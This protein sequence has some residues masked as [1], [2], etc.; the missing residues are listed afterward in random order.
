MDLS[1]AEAAKLL[2]ASVDTV[3]RWI[4]EGSL[5]AHRMGHRYRLNR[6][7][8]Q[9]WAARCGRRVAPELFTADG[10][11][12]VMLVAALE[13]GGIHRNIAG[14]RREDLLESITRLAGIPDDV[15]RTTLYQLLLARE[16]LASTSIG[17]GI[18]LPHPRDPVVMRLREPRILLCFPVAPIDFGAVDGE[19]VRALFLLL[20]P[21]VRDHLRV[22]ARLAYALHDPELA[23]IL[24]PATYDDAILARF[25]AIERG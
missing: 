7:E 24:N 5:P 18:A 6:V 13:R 12:P 11:A 9:E 25:R 10:S 3:H 21:S 4:R 20:S 17:R 16:A 19:P 22:L 14:N 15:D 8:L 1:V 23:L 2:A